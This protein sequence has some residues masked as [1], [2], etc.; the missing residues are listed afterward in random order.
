MAMNA[1]TSGTVFPLIRHVDPVATIAY[2]NGA[3]ITAAQFLADVHFLA[4]TLLPRPHVINRCVDRY[5]FAVGF[6]AALLRRQITLLPPN[7]TPEVLRQLAEQ[8]PGVYCLTDE[9]IAD[10]ILDEVSYPPC[11]RAEIPDFAV[12]AF[13]E[14]QIAALV[15]TSGSTGRP[16][17]HAK[18]WGTLAL[19]TRRAGQRLGVSDLPDAAVVATVPPQHAY[20]LW[21]SVVLAFQNGLALTAPRLFYP[22]DIVQALAA[23]PAPR[24]LVTT[25][26]HLR[27]LTDDTVS[28]PRADLLVCSTA[29]L[30]QALAVEAE[31]RF[32]CRLIEFF[33]CTEAGAIATRR[34]V[35]EIGWRCLEGISLSQDERG[36]WVTGDF[37]DGQVLLSDVIELH[38]SQSFLV[39][40]RTADLVKIAGK[41]TS[42]AHLNFH[43]NAIAGVKD[44]VFVIPE[45][46][47]ES[48]TRLAA[49]VV[50]PS[51]SAQ[52]VLRELSNRI[53]PVFLPRPLCFVEALP[54]NPTGKLTRTDVETLLARADRGN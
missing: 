3:P 14:D 38:G 12:P 11:P 53:D 24:I 41:R 42:L 8:Y 52:A 27:L 33:G 46:S 47:D 21:F 32:G 20:G 48:R 54:R 10:P 34:S 40:G 19:S 7:D 1:D 35:H 44:G 9:P 36:T 50:A 25:P 26:T 43:L 31:A 30:P 49:F 4:D 2:R 22:A 45:G 37:V 6:A 17:P 15:F 39:L 16:T 29:P 23:L 5:H 18:R 51:L 28:S 13:H